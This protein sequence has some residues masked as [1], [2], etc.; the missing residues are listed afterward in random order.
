VLFFFAP[1]YMFPEAAVAL[2]LWKVFPILEEA[3][4]VSTK[5][6]S[7]FDTMRLGLLLTALVAV[8]SRFLTLWKERNEPIATG[9]QS[10]M[11]IS[12]IV[13]FVLYVILN[14]LSGGI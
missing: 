11:L 14:Y 5:D 6:K 13:G 9:R 7:V 12:L 2:G 4:V 8:L 10:S 3:I 1:F